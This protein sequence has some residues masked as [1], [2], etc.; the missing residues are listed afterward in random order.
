MLGAVLY[1]AGM[2]TAK[3]GYLKLFTSSELFY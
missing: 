3:Q 1:T 2:R